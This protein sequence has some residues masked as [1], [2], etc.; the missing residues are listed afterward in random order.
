MRGPYAGWSAKQRRGQRPAALHLRG[1]R[2]GGAWRTAARAPAAGRARPSAAARAAAPRRRSSPRPP[3]RGPRAP[4][5]ARRSRPRPGPRA[6]RTRTRRPSPSR[7]RIASW[8]GPAGASPRF[9]GR[10]EPAHVLAEVERHPARAAAERARA[11]PDDLAARAELVEPGRRP[12]AEPARQHVALPRLGREGDALERDEHLAQ[13]VDARRRPAGRR[14]R[15][16]TP[17]GSAR[18]ASA[19]PPRPPCAASRATRGAGGAG[20]PGRTTRARARR[21]A[22]RRARAPPSRSSSRSTGPG[23]MP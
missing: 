23:S 15:P 11:D 13:P 7:S 5:A 16:A 4:P 21:G 19:R 12:A 14:R 8:C 1:A 20:R 18:A 6:G 2:A 10:P 9:V 22:A 17:A 3:R